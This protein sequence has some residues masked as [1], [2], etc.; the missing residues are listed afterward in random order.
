MNRMLVASVTLAVA[1]F[2]CRDSGGG[3]GDDVDA[4]VTSDDVRIQDIQ[5][6]AITAGTAVTVKGVIVTV[7]D[8]Y[9]GKTGDFWV[10]EPGGGEFSGVHVYGAELSDVGALAVGDLVDIEGAEKDE[11]AYMGMNGSGG[12]TSGRSVTELKP[13]AGGKMKVTKVS[14]GPVPAPQMVD[15]LAIGMKAT[16]AERDAEWEKWEGVLIKLTNVSAT[17]SAACVGSACNDDTLNKFDAT[18]GIVVES[19]LAPFPGYMPAM[20]MTDAVPGDI[21][22]ADCLA[23]VTGVV[24]YFF[25]YLLLNTST[26]AIEKNGTGCPAAEGASHAVCSDN[27][28]NDGNGF[29]DCMDNGCVLGDPACRAQT[30]IAAVQATTPMGYVELTD[31]YVTAIAF[32]KKNFWVSSSLASAANEGIY[33]FR[34]TGSGV[35]NL[36]SNIVVGA[37]VSI[38]GKVIENNND[39]MGST[40]TQIQPLAVNFV[41]APT[42]QPVAVMGQ[43]VASLLTDSTGEP[44]EGVLVTLTNVKVTTIGT[45]MNFYVSNLA[46]KVGTT[47]TNFKSDD[48]IYRM[49]AANMGVCYSSITGIWSYSV[50]ENAYIFLPRAT[51]VSGNTIDG[52]VAPI[53]TVCP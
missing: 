16:Q 40:V 26:A 30:T 8:T 24:D 52:T 20:G 14:S 10:Q 53:A 33:V 42:A 32:N 51:A 46:Q 37:K 25:D 3:G 11:F 34:G 12:D 45:D 17:S 21:A 47:D 39:M 38:I 44:Y 29:V 31:V 9:G 5:S 1:V 15:A 22:R 49:V 4:P 35:P 7:I 27:I 28:D 48:D 50:F 18:G 19:A 41:A 36:A 6:S 43:T 2:A 13:V 23:G